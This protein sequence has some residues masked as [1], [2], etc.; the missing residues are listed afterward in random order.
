[1]SKDDNHFDVVVIGGGPG[2]YPAAIRAAHSGKKVAIIEA[3]QMGGTC[4][5]RGCIPSKALIACAEVY[6]RIKDAAEFGIS[7]ENSKF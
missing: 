4:L 7:V 2:G 3:N 5:N 1:M 6:N